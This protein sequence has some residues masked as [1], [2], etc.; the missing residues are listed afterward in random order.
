MQIIQGD[1][2]TSL[3]ELEDNSI[4][5]CITSPPYY[6]LRN[7]RVEGQLGH[8]KYPDL[9]IRKLVNVFIHV[10]RVLKDSGTCFV[11]IGD[12]Y[13]KDGDLIGIPETFVKEMKRAGWKR[14]NT[15]IWWKPNAM[16]S[17]AKRRFTIDFEYV[18][19][20]VK[21]TKKYFF[22]TQYE[23][24]SPTTLQESK[25]TVHLSNRK[26]QETRQGLNK[27]KPRKKYIENNIQNPLSIKDRITSGI[28]FGG[29]KAKGYENPT[30]SGKEWIY[31]GKG[32]IKRCVWKIPTHGFS[33]AHFAVYPEKL[34]E[35]CL[36]AGCPEGGTVLDPFFGSGTTGLVALKN[37][38]DFIGI[39][40]SEAYCD[41]ARERLKPYMEQTVLI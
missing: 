2:L 12:S 27:W 20:F 17:S 41:L 9:Y 8:E 23:P 1:A 32:R 31:D 16:P 30:Y 26:S 28:Y 3:G 19:F 5:C 15:I 25:Y 40:L 22:E 11:N 37:N 7:Y 34:V 6:L 35:S 18:Y 36:L 21:N 39:E 14:K 29:K 4:D 38:R 24:L 33:G 10:K 13:D